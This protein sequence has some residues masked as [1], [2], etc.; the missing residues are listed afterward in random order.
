MAE[1]MVIPSLVLFFFG[2]P[3]PRAFALH[4]ISLVTNKVHILM[5]RTVVCFQVDPPRRHP[6]LRAPGKLSGDL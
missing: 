3:F 1:F 6:I 4:R 5:D 2:A